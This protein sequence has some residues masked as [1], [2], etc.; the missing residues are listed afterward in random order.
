MNPTQFQSGASLS[1]TLGLQPA[2]GQQSASGQQPTSGPS[3][4]GQPTRS[5]PARRSAAPYHHMDSSV[6]R[7]AGVVQRAS[8]SGS[9]SADYGLASSGLSDHS[10]TVPTQQGQQIAIPASLASASS[11]QLVQQ[12]DQ[13]VNVSVLQPAAPAPLT[14][15]LPDLPLDFPDDKDSH[16]EYKNDAEKYNSDAPNLRKSVNSWISEGA[17]KPKI[18]QVLLLYPSGMFSS[19]AQHALDADYLPLLQAPCSSSYVHTC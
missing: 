7:S 10:D 9:Q 4:A 5:A 16:Y 6:R 18:Q 14:F 17:T 19:M 8:A 12:P 1:C 15:D 13:Q 3:A 11:Q 2:A